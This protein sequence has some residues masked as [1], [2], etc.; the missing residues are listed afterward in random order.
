[1]K[2]FEKLCKLYE[3]IEIDWINVALLNKALQDA[4]IPF[5]SLDIQSAELIITLEGNK[6]VLIQKEDTANGYVINVVNKVR[7]S[8]TYIDRVDKADLVN[9]I[10]VAEC[11]DAL[12]FGP[13]RKEQIQ[14]NADFTDGACV[15]NDTTVFVNLHFIPI[16]EKADLNIA[17]KELKT[18]CA[19]KQVK[20]LNQK[21]LKEVMALY[22]AYLIDVTRYNETVKELQ[23]AWKAIVDE[24]IYRG[25]AD[26]IRINNA[27]EKRFSIEPLLYADTP[28]SRVNALNNRI[29][30]L[31]QDLKYNEYTSISL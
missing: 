6:Q 3:A 30:E 12:E 15:S 29:Q 4:N 10:I 14:V 1:M 11:K 23:E 5:E 16:I 31:L 7:N 26:D 27:N 22:D 17:F 20:L 8:N 28:I 19:E 21:R 25:Y 2:L 9:M 13:L 18:I 24:G